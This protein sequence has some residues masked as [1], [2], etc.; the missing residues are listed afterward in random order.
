MDYLN[1]SIGGYLGLFCFIIFML[2]RQMQ[3]TSS[4]INI[5]TGFSMIN[6]KRWHNWVEA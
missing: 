1:I 3:S 2:V 5:W 6:T 4:N